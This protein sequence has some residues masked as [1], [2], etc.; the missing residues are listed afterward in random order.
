[1]ALSVLGIGMTVAQAL[2]GVIG[3]LVH[4]PSK[5]YGPFAFAVLNALVVI[6]LL[7]DFGGS[8]GTRTRDLLRNKSEGRTGNFMRIAHTGA[9]AQRATNGFGSASLNAMPQQPD[10]L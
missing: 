4:D 10:R 1:M 8:D 6:R 5:T 9:L 2:D 7:G 3:A